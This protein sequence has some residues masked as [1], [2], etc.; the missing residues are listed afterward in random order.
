[1][2][3]GAGPLQIWALADIMNDSLPCS[4]IARHATHLGQAAIIAEGLGSGNAS[5]LELHVSSCGGRASFVVASISVH[6]TDLAPCILYGRFINPATRDTRSSRVKSTQRATA[7]VFAPK[8]PDA[9]D[10]GYAEWG[11]HRMF[12]LSGK[13]A[14]IAPTENKMQ[15][16]RRP[17]RYLPRCK[18]AVAQSSYPRRRDVSPASPTRIYPS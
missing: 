17:V 10:V 13:S 6:P 12:A 7:N 8:L 2:C 9:I 4:V 11:I 16:R 18:L 15:T 3:T 14:F 1:M 5:S